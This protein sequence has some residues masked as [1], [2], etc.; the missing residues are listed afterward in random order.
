MNIDGVDGEVVFGRIH[1]RQVA[2]EDRAEL[3]LRWQ[4]A[5]SP[6]C[7]STR[8][9]DLNNRSLHWRSGS[10]STGNVLHG[11]SD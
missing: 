7:P 10:S 4:G 3:R 5:S 11:A 2:G 1:I 8:C 6:T 9:F